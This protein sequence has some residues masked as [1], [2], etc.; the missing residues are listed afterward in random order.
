MV[1]F[2][3]NYSINEATLHS[4]FNRCLNRCVI[5]LGLLGHEDEVVVGGGLRLGLEVVHFCVL[6]ALSIDQIYS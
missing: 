4:P 3:Y 2:Y 6:R 5:V 1:E